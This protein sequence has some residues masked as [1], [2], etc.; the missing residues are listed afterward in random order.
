MMNVRMQSASMER[1]EL[2]AILRYASLVS[3]SEILG[4]CKAYWLGKDPVSTGALQARDLLSVSC[5][6]PPALAR[7]YFLA[8]TTHAIVLNSASVHPAL[9]HPSTTRYIT[10]SSHDAPY[11]KARSKAMTH[12]QLARFQHMPPAERHSRL[13]SSSLSA[14]SVL[15]FMAGLLEHEYSLKQYTPKPSKLCCDGWFYCGWKP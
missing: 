3:L 13:G 1:P 5:T 4:S 7:R 10:W 15:L 12:S 2:H 14:L 9:C 8:F 11:R 6:W